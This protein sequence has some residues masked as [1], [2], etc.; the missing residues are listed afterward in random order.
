[1]ASRTGEGMNAGTTTEELDQKLEEG[2]RIARAAGTMALDYFHRRAELA[3]EAKG[4]QDLV[5]M[6]DRM[7]EGLIRD[8]LEKHFPKDGILG[9]EH[10]GSGGEGRLWIIDPIDGTANFLRGMP[11]WSVVLAYLEDGKPRFGITMDPIHDELFVGR[12]GVGAVMNGEPIHVS[13]R[14]KPD[15]SCIGLSYSFKTPR[16]SYRALVDR[17]M[18]QGFD[19]RRMGSTA[20][21][22][23]H[24]ADGRLEGAMALRT[25]SWDV[26]AGLCLVDAAGGVATD[27]T[28]G[29]GLKDARA[30]MATTP[31]FAE[32]VQAALDWGMPEA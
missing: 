2:C 30:V 19:H 1:M 15:E 16:P 24:V 8:E 31:A 11:Y 18:A 10:G 12:K 5:S 20:L 32:T 27:F 9:E 21:S 7:V 22:L 26:I 23:C 4:T 25:Q 14:E 13:T 29:V 6:A 17:L 3:I 28:D